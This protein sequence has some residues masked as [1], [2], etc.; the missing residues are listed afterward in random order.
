MATKIMPVGALRVQ[1]RL[2]KNCPD[3]MRFWDVYQSRSEMM[4]KPDHDFLR[5]CLLLGFLLSESKGAAIDLLSSKELVL[6]DNE[7][8]NNQS[9]T[10]QNDEKKI[11]LSGAFLS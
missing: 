5:R 3:D 11:D 1:L 6:S 7:S 9:K 4:G 10:A 2:R 8:N